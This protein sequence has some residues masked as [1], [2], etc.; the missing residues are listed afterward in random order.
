MSIS[1][2]SSCQITV[3]SFEGRKFF[4]S[5]RRMNSEFPRINQPAKQNLQLFVVIKNLQCSCLSDAPK[6]KLSLIWY[7][8]SK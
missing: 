6:R 5:V 4:L 8:I 1:A 3:I 2:Y 7:D